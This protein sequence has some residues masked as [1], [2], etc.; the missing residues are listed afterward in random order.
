MTEVQHD[1]PMRIRGVVLRG[2]ARSSGSP[3][4]ERLEPSLAS[5]VRVRRW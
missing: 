2:E 1:G 5:Y 3:I 4:S